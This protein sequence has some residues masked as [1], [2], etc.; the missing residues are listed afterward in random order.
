MHKINSIGNEPKQKITLLLNENTQ[1]PFTLE[2]RANQT[3][4][5]FSFEFDGQTY[6]NIRL[7]TSY[8]ILRGYK[9]WLDFG[10]R[11]D[12]T[13]G[14][15]PIDIDD[16]ITGYASIYLLTKEDV[17]TIESNYYVKTTA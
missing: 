14:Q 17:E 15:E 16:F 3:G 2:Y 9:N 7:T 5:F 4:W 10:I 12:T 8:N 11:C 1:T 13:D 6:Q